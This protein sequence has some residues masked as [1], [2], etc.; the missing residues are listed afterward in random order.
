[1]FWSERA[2]TLRARVAWSTVGA[3]LV[4]GAIVA[5]VGIGLG[6][7]LKSEPSPPPPPVPMPSTLPAGVVVYRPSF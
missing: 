4:G 5:I 7:G 6:V 3:A 2:R 1:M